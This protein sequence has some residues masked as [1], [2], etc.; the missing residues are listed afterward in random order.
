MP[1]KS[2]STPR[3]HN[4]KALH[5]FEI[6]EKV[7]CGLVL[8]GTEVKSLRDGQGTLDESFARIES[9]EAWLLGFHIAPYSHGRT[10]SHE[11]K[12]RRKLLLQRRE[13]HKLEV[14]VTQKG[15]TLVP[16]EVYFS[17]RGLVKVMLA[18]ARGKSHSDKRQA[19][20]KAEHKREM[21]RALRRRR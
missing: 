3:I 11:P 8:L 9:G 1:E 14:K 16:L 7:Q 10:A 13:I 18:L 19:L 15:L 4:R 2:P 6:L 5:R 17:D 21:D 12:R 20:K